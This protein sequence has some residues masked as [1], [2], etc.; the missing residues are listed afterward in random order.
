MTNYDDRYLKRGVSASKSEVHDSIKNADRGLFPGAF[1]KIIEDV[2][3]GDDAFCNIMH[4][5]GAGTKSSLAYIYY[6]E[7][8]DISVFR[9]I[10]QDSLVMNV[11]DVI[12]AGAVSNMLFSNTIG[13]NKHLIPGEVIKEIIAGYEEMI[14]MLNDNGVGIR[15]CGGETA[16]VGDLVKTVIADSTIAV[17][18]KRADVIDNSNIAPEDV[19]VALASHGQAAYEKHYN[20]GIGSNGLTS[21][22]HDVFTKIYMDK[23]PESFAD[24]TPADYV[25]CGKY[26]LTDDFGHGGLTVGQAVLSPTRTYAPVLKKVFDE[27]GRKNIHGIVHNSG[28]GQVKCRSFGRGVVYV[29]D[30]MMDIPP[31]FELIRSS[32]GTDYPEMYQVF[33]MGSRMEVILPERYAEEVM[34]VAGSFN[35]DS[36][37]IGFVDKNPDSCESNRVIITAPDGRKIE[38]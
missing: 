29:K 30:S 35:I 4:A 36:K 9:G 26:N 2:L 33:N 19:I 32:S 21:A 28:G 22:R 20:A 10:A 17:R 7:T 25:Y 16:D 18:M 38:Y 6:R 23:Y 5:D 34:S 11:D 15:S 37:V 14:A 13:R 3:G 12:A 31:L 8:G 1:C 27:I 24:K